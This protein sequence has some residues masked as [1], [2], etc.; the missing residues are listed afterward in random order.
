MVES[1]RRVGFRLEEKEIDQG[2][3]DL[4]RSYVEVV[5]CGSGQGL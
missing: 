3:R 1:L 5:V 4:G 2:G